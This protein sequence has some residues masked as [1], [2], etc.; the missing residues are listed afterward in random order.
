MAVV[1]LGCGFAAGAETDPYEN[2]VKTSKDFRPVKQDKAWLLKAYPS[3][4]YMPWTH[5]WTIGYNDDSG[6]WCVK[7]GYNGAFIDRG[8]VGTRNSKTGR[9]DWINKFGFRF[10]VDHLAGKRELHLWDGGIPKNVLDKVH[11]G[12]I[13][14]NP[15]N[16]A[17]RRRLHKLMAQHIAAVKSSPLRAAYALDDEISWGHFVHP[18]MWRVTDDEAA[19]PAWLKEIYGPGAP[20]RT[21]WVTYE[22]VRPKLPSWSV[23]DFDASAL[24][25]QWTFND[26]YWNNFIGDLVEFSNRLDPE[27]PCGWVGGQ[28]PNAFGGYDYAKLMRKVQFIESYNIGGSQA[29]IR[30]FNPHNAIPAVTS[31]FHRSSADTIWQT[32]YYLAHGNRGFIGWVEKWFDG[33]T[34]KPW[35]DE[36]APHF[37]AAG[38]KIGPLM[39]GAEWLHDGVAIYYNHASIQ[40][41]WI[42]DA[43]AHSKSWINRNGDAR[44]GSAHQGR[45][46]W[47][48]MLRDSGLQYNYLN[49]VDVIQN[50]IPADYKVLILPGCLCLSDVEAKRIRAF[51]EAGGT[52]VADFMPGLWDQHGK[53]RANGGVLDDVFGVK[54][55]PDLKASGVFGGKLWCELDQDANFS[56]KTYQDFLSRG[57]KCIKDATGFDK[58]VRDLQVVKVNRV[59]KG[60]AVLMNLSPQWYNAY[61]VAGAES[62]AKRSAFI[63]HVQSATGKR[64]VSLRGG[65]KEHGYE[66]TYWK[67][68]GRTVLFVCMNPEIAV[69]STGGGN[70]VGLKEDKLAVT[71]AFAGKLGGVRDER[72]GKDLG[73]GSEFKFD[74]K[75]NEAI[76]LSFDGAPPRVP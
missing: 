62:A 55:D 31:H 27:T 29:V 40:L 43:A 38:Q 26:S 70:S 56:W 36:V 74:W 14:V 66:I 10:Y 51:A 20:Q 34:P 17:M 22:D 33:T 30:S 7:H 18:T 11:G 69:S 54:H 37:L 35:H 45:K 46:A 61:R 12:G 5:Q 52:V 41:G 42:L 6:K 28:S 67:K 1:L 49:Y 75:M 8:D 44:I 68:N 9:I 57:N 4:L 47:E 13:R 73:G 72:T 58:A 65:G 64:W 32:W 39:S 24:M 71:L 76:V 50:G 53:G 15:V 25:D 60:T 23:K 2:Y 59:G 21:R 63:D 16:E 19:Y 3:W 48:N